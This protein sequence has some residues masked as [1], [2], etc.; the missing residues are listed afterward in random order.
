[1]PR[2]QAQYLKLTVWHVDT[3]DLRP[4]LVQCCTRTWQAIFSASTN[5]LDTEV[6]QNKSVENHKL[7]NP[8]TRVDQ[9]F[10]KHKYENASRYK[11]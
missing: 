10:W 6:F 1:M 5:L 9:I 7:I 11:F 8:A 2:E 3:F 4:T